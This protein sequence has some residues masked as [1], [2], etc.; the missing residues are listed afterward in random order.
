MQLSENKNN[1]QDITC[2]SLIG[3]SMAEKIS[4]AS[5]VNLFLTSYGTDSLYVSCINGKPGVVYVAPSIGNHK[6]L[7]VHR[8]ITEVPENFITEINP[9]GKPW[10]EVSV[11]ITWRNIYNCIEEDLS[12]PE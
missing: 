6:S 8:K 4:H 1:L 3:H 12:E 7:H 11:S 2:I 10:S 5:A 9:D